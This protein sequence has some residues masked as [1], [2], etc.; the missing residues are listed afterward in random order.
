MRRILEGEAVASPAN[1]SQPHRIES[2]DALRGL[3]VFVW[4]LAALGAPVLDQM[5]ESTLATTVAAQLSPSF[6]NGITIYDLVLPMFLFVAGAS[7]V[8]AFERRRTAGQSDRRLATRIVRRVILLSAIGL[9]CEGGLLQ[10]WPSLRLVGAF[11]RIAICYA[12]VACL[13]RATGW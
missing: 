1:T 10:Y 3:T 9:L 5:P 12:V 11:Q 7:I 8:P 6:W 2:L 13:N 4:L